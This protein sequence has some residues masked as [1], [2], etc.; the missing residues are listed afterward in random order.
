MTREREGY[1]SPSSLAP[2]VPY[3]TPL[4]QKRRPPTLRKRP[5]TRGRDS[6]IG[7]C[8]F[9]ARA[10]SIIGVEVAIKDLA[11]FYALYMDVGEQGVGCACMAIPEIRTGGIRRCQNLILVRADRNR[12]ATVRDEAVVPIDR[13]PG[14]AHDPP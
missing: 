7:T 4:T 1:G 11:L 2:N 8:K 6:S 13:C 5:H 12:K 14:T 10:Q 9:G 3:V